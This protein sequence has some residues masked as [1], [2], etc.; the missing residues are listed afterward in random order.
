MRR[1]MHKLIVTRA[2]HGANYAPRVKLRLDPLPDRAFAGMKRAAK[3]QTGMTKC[4]NDHLK[5]L[6]R[7]LWK[8][9]GRPWNKVYKEIC[10]ALDGRSTVKEHVHLHL[11]DFIVRQ[12]AVGRD[13]RWLGQLSWGRPT[14]LEECRAR[15]YVDPQDGIIKETGK[16]RRKLG[17]PEKWRWCQPPSPL[18]IDKIVLSEDTELLLL[19]GIWYRIRFAKRP[20]MGP[21]AKVFDLLTR[22]SVWAGRRH[23]VLKRQLSKAELETHGL[24]NRD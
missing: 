3:Q 14:P 22:E 15:L 2:R 19:G 9:R 23:A 1:D 24:R 5:P 7:F 12:V 13:G 4:F 6:Q 21:R 11:D 18:P 10:D 16:Y 8:Q 20:D 17:L